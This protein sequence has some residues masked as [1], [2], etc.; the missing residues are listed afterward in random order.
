MEVIPKHY[1]VCQPKSH[2]IKKETTDMIKYPYIFQEGP[3]ESKE[4][5]KVKRTCVGRGDAVE[6]EDGR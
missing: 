2:K 5:L 6:K 1:Q 3:K 4:S